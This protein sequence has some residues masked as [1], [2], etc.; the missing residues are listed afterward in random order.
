MSSDARVGHN[1]Q[2]AVDPRNLRW[3][4]EIRLGPGSNGLADR[5][6]ELTAIKAQLC[7]RLSN[8]E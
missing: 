7:N 5:F 6:E 2:A 8:V 1:G 4:E 3:H